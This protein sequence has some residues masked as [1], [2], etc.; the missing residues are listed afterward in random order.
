VA[1]SFLN[2]YYDLVDDYVADPAKSRRLTKEKKL[3]DFPA[4][5]QQVWERLVGASGQESMIGRSEST[6]TITN[7]KSFYELPGNFRTFIQFEYRE[8]GDRQSGAVSSEK[9]PAL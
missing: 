4:I 5:E 9:H 7:D 1:E 8:S 2:R 6:V 3:R